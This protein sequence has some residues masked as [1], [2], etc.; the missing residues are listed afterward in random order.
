MPKNVAIR[1]LLLALFVLAGCSSNTVLVSVPPR[2]DLKSYGTLGIVNF[3]SNGD[4]NTS[5]RATRLFQEQVQSAQPGTPFVELGDRDVLLGSVGAKQLDGAA[6][7]KIGEKYGVRAIF[8]G[9]LVYQEPRTDIKVSDITKLDGGVRTEMRGDISSRLVETASGASVW[10]SSAWARRQIGAL[11]VSATEGM[12]GG[13]SQ[14]NPRDEMVPAL[15][16]H[17][18]EDFR[19]TSVRQPVK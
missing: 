8:L 9:D 12:S 16:F 3:A 4:M 14:S 7:R 11:H 1:F 13:V 2:M 5:S 19:P 18:T 6:L 10:S 15:V 17:L